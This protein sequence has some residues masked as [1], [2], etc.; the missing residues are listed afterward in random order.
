[1]NEINKYVKTHE[2]RFL[3]EL[4]ELIRIPSISSLPEISPLYRAAENGKRYTA[5]RRADKAEVNGNSRNPVSTGKK[6]IDKESAYP[7]GLRGYGRD[8][9]DPLELWQTDPIEP[10]VKDGK[11]MG[12][13]RGR[14]K[15]HH[16]IARQ[17]PS[18]TSVAVGVKLNCNG[19]SSSREERWESPNLP[20]FLART[21]RR[22]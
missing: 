4:F 11:I 15:G 18:S 9:G 6:I 3:D 2:K 19:S 8:A 22:C 12:Q 20:K 14:D 1:M 7:A 5:G 17:G 13:G 16:T 10:V 21:Q